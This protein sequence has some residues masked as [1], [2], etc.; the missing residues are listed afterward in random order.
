MVRTACFLGLPR[1]VVNAGTLYENRPEVK[2]RFGA[3][4][5]GYGVEVCGSIFSEHSSGTMLFSVEKTAS[6]TL[7]FVR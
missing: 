7:P 1:L 2:G 6:A 5:E 3:D 4:E